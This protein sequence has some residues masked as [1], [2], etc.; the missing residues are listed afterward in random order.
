[1][2]KRILFLFVIAFFLVFCGKKD[3]VADADHNHEHDQSGEKVEMVQAEQHDDHEQQDKQKQ[4]A[5]HDHL[6][7]SEKMIRE[8]GIEFG[9]PEKRDYIEKIMSTGVLKVNKNTT[10]L[11]NSLVP[12]VVTA[13]KKDIGD[14]VKKGTVLCVLNSPEL[15]SLKTKFI[16]AH[17]EFLLTMQNYGRAKNLFESK[18]IEKKELIK[19][20]AKY[21]TS[22]A[23]YL[24]LEA[25]LHSLGFSR[26]LLKE[27]TDSLIA[28]GTGKLKEFLSPF[29]Y[30][31][32]P[33]PGKVVSR[34]LIPGE[35]IEID[36]TIF[37]IS[38]TGKLWAI[39]DVRETDLRFIEKGRKVDI[40]CDVYPAEFFSGRITAIPEKVDSELR[41]IKVRVE[42]ANEKYLL[43]PEM[44][45]RGALQKNIKKAALSV[46]GSA[47]VKMSGIPGV[48]LKEGDGFEFKPVQVIDRDSAGF[49]FVTGLKADETI[50]TKGT[51]YLKA[52]YEIKRGAVD[53]HA[54]HQH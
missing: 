20:E 27:L 51:F 14:R 5:G 26:K 8:W 48:F 3:H 38:D 53:A 11:I 39:L 17:Q 2:K 1:M 49:A 35:R 12:G 24:S 54:G 34:D 6:H 50:V 33:G 36:K 32:A 16:K 25:E 4:E 19:R 42:V 18:A 28:G 31:P 13:V 40:L 44:Y 37:E 45:V 46:P 9:K 21:R 23:D 22:L 43:K 7:V 47:V 41:T 30:I 52:E 10:F 15:L 29:Y